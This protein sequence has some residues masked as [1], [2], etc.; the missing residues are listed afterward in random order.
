MGQEHL[1]FPIHPVKIKFILIVP[2]VKGMEGDATPSPHPGEGTWKE[3][4][5]LGTQFF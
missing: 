4:A 1:I 5:A 3:G 2:T